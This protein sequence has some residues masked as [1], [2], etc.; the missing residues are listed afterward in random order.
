MIP[1]EVSDPKC[2]PVKWH[3][4]H[5][6][7]DPKSRREQLYSKHLQGPGQLGTLSAADCRFSPRFRDIRTLY[8]FIMAQRPPWSATMCAA[9]PEGLVLAVLSEFLGT[10]F[11]QVISALTAS[12]PLASGLAYSGLVYGTINL[13]GGHLNPAITLA[14][15]LTGHFNVLTGV[16]YII[17]QI[18]GALLGAI[19]EILL[20]PGLKW[21]VNPTGELGCFLHSG[22]NL[23]NYQILAW[24]LIFTFLLVWVVYATAISDRGTG[25]MAPL[26]LGIIVF[27]SS[28]AGQKYFGHV[29]A[30]NPA[31]LLGS[32]A[33]FGCSI[34][35]F[36]IFLL[37]EFMASFLAAGLALAAGY[38]GEFL[39]FLIPA[40]VS[41][42]PTAADPAI[43]LGLREPLVPPVLPRS[44]NTAGVS[45][46]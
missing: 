6:L 16:A 31:R 41:A 22:L 18:L 21:H 27:I 12:N 7:G 44:A 37:A 10:A 39:P 26:A 33:A 25:K 19:V 2:I 3:W 13:S 30:L 9:R 1:N 17:A 29:L 46:V 5:R 42:Y 23:N 15:L 40:P 8:T 38:V 34:R 20:V 45:P 36:W 14:V 43:D 4:S 32:G 11:L 35:Q 28:V 24:E